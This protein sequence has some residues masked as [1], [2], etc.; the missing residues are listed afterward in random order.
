[1]AYGRRFSEA[2]DARIVELMLA[3][4]TA[5]VISEAIGR[6]VA[7]TKSRIKFLRDEGRLPVSSYRRNPGEA[8][9]C[10]RCELAPRKVSRTGRV[11][12]YCRGCDLER[13]GDYQRTEAGRASAARSRAKLRE[14]RERER[15]G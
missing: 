7:S 15:N 13:Q 12:S 6:T 10:P 1:M 11:G 2:E 8:T 14:R 5:K 4:E 3:G 9:M